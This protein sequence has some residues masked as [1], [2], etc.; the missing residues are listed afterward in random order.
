MDLVPQLSPQTV[1]TPSCRLSLA[2]LLPETPAVTLTS[3]PVRGPEPGGGSSG[4]RRQR[5]TPAPAD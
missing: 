4:N 5:Q 1:Q 3:P 2:L